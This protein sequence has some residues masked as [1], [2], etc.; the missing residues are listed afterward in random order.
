MN[1]FREPTVF[2]TNWK[3]GTTLRPTTSSGRTVDDVLACKVEKKHKR[4]PSA[5]IPDRDH[6]Y[7]FFEKR[8]GFDCPRVLA[9]HELQEQGGAADSQAP[10]QV[11][12]YNVIKPSPGQQAYARVSASMYNELFF[13]QAA[14]SGLMTLGAQH[15]GVSI[16]GGWMQGGGHNPFAHKF[17][18]QVDSVV[19]IEVVTT[20]GKFLKASKCSNS[21]L[22]W[23]LRGGG[24][25]TYVGIT[26]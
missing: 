5:A 19:E 6:D 7:K 25:S 11:D 22:F 18:M 24:G 21:D 16:T 10:K 15:G 8:D 12:H 26:H 4:S 13:S 23:A 17:G 3:C 9:L 14:K 2:S 1:S 20:D